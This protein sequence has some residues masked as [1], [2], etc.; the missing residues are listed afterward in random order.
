MPDMNEMKANLQQELEDVD[1]SLGI[2]RDNIVREREKVRKLLEE[3]K[4]IERLLGAIDR[5][6]RT[7]KKAS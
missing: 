5:K 3:K 7:S 6:P 1:G 2:S 4:A